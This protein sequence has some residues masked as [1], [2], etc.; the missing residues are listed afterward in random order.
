MTGMRWADVGQDVASLNV[1]GSGPR[2][3]NAFS[4]SEEASRPEHSATEGSGPRPSASAEK[5]PRVHL[6]YF[7]LG[8]HKPIKSVKSAAKMTAKHLRSY[9]K[10]A[11]IASTGSR[12]E[13]MARYNDY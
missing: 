6:D 2:L 11:S 12:V 1:R 10:E 13:L 8:D 9:L 7:F 4:D 5:D 3:L